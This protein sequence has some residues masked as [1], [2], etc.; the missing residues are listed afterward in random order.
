MPKIRTVPGYIEITLAIALALSLIG[1]FLAMRNG[2]R[3]TER[4]RVLE[5][6][7]R[8]LRGAGIVVATPT[9]LDQAWESLLS[10]NEALNQSHKS[11]TRILSFIDGLLQESDNQTAALETISPNLQVMS[12][13]IQS[14]AEAAQKQLE[15]IENTGKVFEAFNTSTSRLFDIITVINDK[16]ITTLS[17][18]KRGSE[19][20]HG[21]FES[22][23]VVHES[24]S[25]IGQIIN[26][27]RGIADKTNLLSL[28]AAIEAARAGEH[29]RGF[30]V[31]ADEV[32]KLAEKSSISV[33][34]IAGILN[35][36]LETSRKGKD[37][38]DLAR[39]S[40]ETIST[41][42]LDMNEQIQDVNA[43]VGSEKKQMQDLQNQIHTL[44]SASLEISGSIQNQSIQS[45]ELVR[46]IEILFETTKSVAAGVRSVSEL[47]EEIRDLK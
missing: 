42:I 14:I 41:S 31:V 1:L 24:L 37:V 2:R 39:S 47:L 29:G 21:S 20:I 40:F 3:T 33:K 38:S 15:V 36:N 19:T 12:Y 35:D 23:A 44:K 4:L 30:A 13:S 25:K 28:N 18:A 5:G 17:H 46:S 45:R 34:Q 10:R 11:L 27:I 16:S 26:A 9:A 22:M 7:L 6:T 8:S 32:S 43:Y